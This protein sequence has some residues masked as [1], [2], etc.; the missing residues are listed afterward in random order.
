MTGAYKRDM[1]AKSRL[2]EGF[3]AVPNHVIREVGQFR[4]KCVVGQKSVA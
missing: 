3:S 2:V 4:W 1:G